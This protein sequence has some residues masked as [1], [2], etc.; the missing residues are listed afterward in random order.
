MSE[1]IP[2]LAETAW[3]DEDETCMECGLD[4]PR[5]ICSTLPF[6]DVSEYVGRHRS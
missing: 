2:S 4:G 1:R 3:Y 5:C 6:T